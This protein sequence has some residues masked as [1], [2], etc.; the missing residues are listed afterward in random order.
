MLASLHGSGNGRG[1]DGGD[2]EFMQIADDR[3]EIAE[4]EGVVQ[5]DAVSAGRDVHDTSIFFR[6]RSRTRGLFLWD[7]RVRSRPRPSI[8]DRPI[9]HL[10]NRTP[11]PGLSI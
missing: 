6:R 10:P 3:G 11:C 9:V 5:L 2:A 4:G 7:G 8:R 1:I